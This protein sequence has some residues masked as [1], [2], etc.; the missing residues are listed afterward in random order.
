MIG[1]LVATIKY[2]NEVKIYHL[3]N[4][5]RSLFPSLFFFIVFSTPLSFHFSFFLIPSWSLGGSWFAVC[6]MD[7]LPSLPQD[8]IDILRVL[9]MN[10]D[11]D[12]QLKF[13]SFSATVEK[14]VSERNAC[15]FV[16]KFLP[17]PLPPQFWLLLP[18]E[19]P[20]AFPN[21]FSSIKRLHQCYLLTILKVSEA[22][23][24]LFKQPI[25]IYNSLF[26]IEEWSPN[27]NYDTFLHV[28]FF[29][30]WVQL[31]GIAEDYLYEYAARE[32]LD[33][34]NLEIVIK[35]DEPSLSITYGYT[36]TL[37]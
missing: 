3:E 25:I 14:D 27:L 6:V 37:L 31:H 5:F 21:I 12:G 35:D 32:L 17:H 4:C 13:E 11:G 7:P 10:K 15:H 29:F 28:S 1:A 19:V 34:L 23:Q 2:T 22:D 30:C 36:R 20:P 9:H 16:G 26:S 8:I 24:F 18:S 33:A